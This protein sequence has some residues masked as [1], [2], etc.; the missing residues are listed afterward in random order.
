MG[1]QMPCGVITNTFGHAH[2]RVNGPFSGVFERKVPASM[3]PVE[4]LARL[5]IEPDEALAAD[6]PRQRILG[7]DAGLL[8]RR[9]VP[10]TTH[11]L[12]LNTCMATYMF[13]CEFET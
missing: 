10:C 9:R 7:N 6:D 12:S 13:A 11:L 1:M 4:R 8:Q 5:R 2:T 3:R